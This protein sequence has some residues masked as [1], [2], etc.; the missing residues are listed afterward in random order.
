MAESYLMKWA[1]QEREQQ[2]RNAFDAAV[3]VERARQV[4]KGYTPEQDAEHGPDHLL[5]WAEEYIY[6]GEPVKAAA[7][8]RAAREVLANSETFGISRD[9]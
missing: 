4:A 6:R 2:D 9:T 5:M 8:M 7:L 3:V 1:R